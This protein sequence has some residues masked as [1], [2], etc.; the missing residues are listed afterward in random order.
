[1]SKPRIP[2]QTDLEEC[3]E[4]SVSPEGINDQPIADYEMSM[5]EDPI[6]VIQP[7]ED[8]SP[9]PPVLQ[10]KSLYLSPAHPSHP[11]NRIKPKTNRPA[12]A[13]DSIRRS[14]LTPAR[15]KPIPA[16]TPSE[17][18]SNITGVSRVSRLPRPGFVRTTVVNPTSTLV[19]PSTIKRVAFRGVPTN[20]SVS[21]VSSYIGGNR[22]IAGV[23]RVAELTQELIHAKS[24]MSHGQATATITSTSETPLRSST[25][26]PH[27]IFDVRTPYTMASTDDDSDLD[28]ADDSFMDKFTAPE[29]SR[30]MLVDDITATT[31]ETDV[32]KKSFMTRDYG[33][34]EEST[35][36]SIHQ[37]S[38]P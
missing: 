12:F 1:M 8:F 21:G 9:V 14:A 30:P 25:N 23:S 31:D 22:N 11:S 6:S 24:M 3:N 38:N 2:A 15:P 17:V 35:I 20:S 10:Y 28:E 16:S 18:M 27:Q 13:P 29:N 33:A 7:S 36:E 5:V 19:P 32:H 37:S 4:N 26:D 34:P